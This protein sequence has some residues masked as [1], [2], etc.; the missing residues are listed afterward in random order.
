MKLKKTF[1]TSLV[2]LAN[3]FFTSIV[4]ASSGH[5]HGHNDHTNTHSDHESMMSPEGTMFLKKQ[6]VDGYD[7]SFHVMK[8]QP[9]KEMGGSH[10]FMIKVEKD[11]KPQG[12]IV[13]NTKVIY[14]NGK[15]ESKKTMKMG[16]WLM[17]GYDLHSEGKHQ[18]MVLFKTADG[19]KHKAGVFYSGNQ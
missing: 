1:F 2:L 9:G 18:L 12:N 17:A 6:K 10:D 15:S 11:G 19:T 5:E 14:P 13:M 7:I 4:V 8:A 3:M 16:D